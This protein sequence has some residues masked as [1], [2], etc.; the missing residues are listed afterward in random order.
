MRCGAV[1]IAFQCDAAERIALG[2]PGLSECAT[3]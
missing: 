2:V 3:G 1:D